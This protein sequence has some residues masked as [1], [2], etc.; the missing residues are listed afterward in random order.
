MSM[1]IAIVRTDRLGDMIL[2]LPM[3]GAIRAVHPQARIVICCRRYLEPVVARTDGID[4]IVYVDDAPDALRM[5]LREEHVDV[6]FHPRP[7]A[8]EV[9]TS[10][11]ARIPRRVGT[12]FRWYSFL[13][14]TRVRDHRRDA[15][16]HEAEYNVRMVEAA[17]G[18]PSLPTA[19][20]RLHTSHHETSFGM[21]GRYF[22][23]H[24]GSGGS[25]RDWPAE[26]FG[27]TARVL[28]DRTGWTPVITGISTEASLC[29][30]VLAAC[31]TAVSMCGKCTLEETMDIVAKAEVV[32]AN[33]TG[34]LHI[35]AAYGRPVVGLYPRTPSMS[36]ERWG[37]Y[38]S[39]AVV[40]ESG[41]DDDM[42]VITVADVVDAALRAHDLHPE[43][44]R[45]T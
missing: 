26:R 45:P 33:S 29:A 38:S 30:K 23:V 5:A 31:P 15:A 16:H 9:W 2:T 32:I 19:L 22:I 14:T 12:A 6:I 43:L 20:P 18:R 34:L 25:A 3:I 4:R 7:H 41:A 24:P 10:V 35:A 21:D 28:A 36:K 40:L 42:T 13:F 39:R 17:F 1:T 44:Y 11:R 8:S 27:E 37:P